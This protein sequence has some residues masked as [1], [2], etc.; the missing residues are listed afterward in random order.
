MDELRLCPAGL[1]LGRV[2]VEG[3]GEYG[4]AVQAKLEGP[5]IRWDGDESE[6]GAIAGEDEVL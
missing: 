2:D 1:L 3:H 4:T 6:F 5:G